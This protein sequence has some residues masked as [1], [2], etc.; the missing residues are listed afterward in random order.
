MFCSERNLP[1]PSCNYQWV[2]DKGEKI[3]VSHNTWFQLGACHFVAVVEEFEKS[4]FQTDFWFLLTPKCWCFTRSPTFSKRNLQFCFPWC[5]P[6]CGCRF[7]HLLQGSSSMENNTQGLVQFHL[8]GQGDCLSKLSKC[9]RSKYGRRFVPLWE[10]L[11]GI[12]HSLPSDSKLLWILH[13]QGHHQEHPL[14]SQRRPPRLCSCLQRSWAV[15]RVWCSR[16]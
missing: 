9:G 7:P 11:K 12:L 16:C 10:A 4:V 13:P 8:L 2:K 6:Y 15:G 3:Q 14:Y 1:F 5:L